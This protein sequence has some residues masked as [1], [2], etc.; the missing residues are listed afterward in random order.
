MAK[1]P[2]EKYKNG[3]SYLK[4]LMPGLIYCMGL[5]VLSWYLEK[6]AYAHWGKNIPLNYVFIAI[7]LGMLT[8]NIFKMGDV[9]QEG[10]NFSTKVFLYIG[11]V[12]IGAKLN[13]V[14]IFKVGSGALV[15]VSIS[16][17][18]MV[19]GAGYI[20]N[21]YQMGHRLGHL[22]GTGIG[23]CGVSAIIATAPA[24]KAT[25]KELIIA[26]GASLLTDVMCL[27]GIPLL[28]HY[29]GW[30]DVFVGYLSGTTPSNTAQCIATG[31]AYSDMAG[32]VATITKSAR[33]ALMPVLI[34]ALVYYYT[35][36]GLPVGEKVRLG[37]L[38][39]KFPK[40]VLGLLVLS[41]LASFGLFTPE[42]VKTTTHL[43]QWFFSFC[44]VG[45]GAAVDFKQFHKRDLAPIAAGFVLTF[46]LFAYA[47]LFAGYVLGAK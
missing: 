18:M 46:I 20:S 9:F 30:N 3:S 2:P 42:M 26:I 45:I 4:A 8:K 29:F 5:G 15:M 41:A 43:Y 22:I 27:F 37:I 44:F 40:F 11:V 34:L 10:I 36:K 39:S 32:N 7:I 33:N 17:T 38:W 6:A 12:L 1:I 25:D 21:K 14:Q 16:I 24:I 31:F 19:L 13:L 28:G 35:K 23:V 47:F